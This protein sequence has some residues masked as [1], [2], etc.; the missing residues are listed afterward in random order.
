MKVI[1]ALLMF[2]T[3]ARADDGFAKW[4]PEFKAAVAKG[5]AKAIVR[6][7]LFPLPWE[8]GKVRNIATEGDFVAHFNTYFTA[9][10]HKAVAEQKPVS[11]PGDQYMITWHARGN[12][13]SLYFKQQGGSFVLF[14]LSEGPP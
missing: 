11:I 13:Y 6:G 2:A 14:A 4:W 5:D 12:E 7:T 10:M 9:D 1:A 3:L 8:L